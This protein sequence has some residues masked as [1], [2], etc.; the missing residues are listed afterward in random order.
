[1]KDLTLKI[2]DLT[3]NASLRLNLESIVERTHDSF[4]IQGES[5]N[6]DRRNL[7]PLEITQARGEKGR[8]TV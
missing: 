1:M 4:E 5:R 3:I 2:K 7:F 6:W 8:Q